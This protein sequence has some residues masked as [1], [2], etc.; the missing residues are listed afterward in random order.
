MGDKKRRNTMKYLV[1]KHSFEFNPKTAPSIEDAFYSSFDP[2]P[3][4]LALFDTIEEANA[5][6]A[7]LEPSVKLYRW[8][9]AHAEVYVVTEC[10]W[11]FDDDY[12]RGD[13][14]EIERTFCDLELFD[15]VRFKA[16]EQ[17]YSE[18][19]CDE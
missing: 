13:D 19:R 11:Y 2:D 10:D 1:R 15:D 5:L 12:Y 3:V 18:L 6:L 16:D 17:R 9:L 14:G 7:T 8:N 4:D